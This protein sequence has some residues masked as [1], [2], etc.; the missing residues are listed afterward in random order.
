MVTKKPIT[1][2]MTK[3]FK[4]SD[5]DDI[6]FCN[7]DCEEEKENDKT[8]FFCRTCNINDCI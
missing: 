2:T 5:E 4:V 3:K 8:D 1:T 6:V 7:D